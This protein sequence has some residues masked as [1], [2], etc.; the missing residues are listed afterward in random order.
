MALLPWRAPRRHAS[1]PKWR[2]GVAGRSPSGSTQFLWR[3]GRNLA[4]ESEARS[5]A[6]FRLPQWSYVSMEGEGLGGFE[7]I[8][9]VVAGAA[10]ALVGAVRC[11][12]ERGSR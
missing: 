11:G 2:F 10:L 12:P 9:I 4:S 6:Q 5:S 1:L 3:A 8:T 7:S